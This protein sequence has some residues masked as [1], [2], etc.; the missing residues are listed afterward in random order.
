M[1]TI[2]HRFDPLPLEP[3]APPALSLAQAEPHVW[4]TDPATEV[5]TDLRVAA[6]VVVPSTEA[7]EDT[8]RLMQFAGVRMAFISE[9]PERIIGLVT[10]ADLQGERAAQVASARGVP[11]RELPVHDVMLPVAHWA[12]IDFARLAWAKV[13][14]LVETFRATGQRYLIVTERVTSHADIAS[15]AV[16]RGLFSANR[17]ERALGRSIE[18][19]LHSRSFAELAGVLTER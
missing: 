4:L 2:P 15:R 6:G 12:R 8:R 9:A 18:D 14:H 1:D 19:G 16:I 7:L 13:G 3:A 5:F 11:Q 17:L 10:L